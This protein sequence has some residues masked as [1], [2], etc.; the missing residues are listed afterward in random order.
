MT[1]VMAVILTV[2]VAAV[3]VLALGFVF[4]LASGETARDSVKFSLA[5][6]G[7][8]VVTVGGVYGLVFLI[9]RIWSFVRSTR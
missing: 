6:L 5:L 1:F 7:V 4:G 9:Q 3:V 2:L 8:L